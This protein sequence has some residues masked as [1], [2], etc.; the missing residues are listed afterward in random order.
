MKRISVLIAVLLITVCT[1]QAAWWWSV[2]SENWQQHQVSTWS[3]A[4]NS[5]ASF[6]G[7]KDVFWGEDPDSLGPWVDFYYDGSFVYVYAVNPGNST[8]WYAYFSNYSDAY[9]AAEIELGSNPDFNGAFVSS[10][11]S[12]SKSNRGKHLGKQ[13]K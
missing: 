5:I 11:T 12:L 13:V 9:A 2:Q 10:S 1:S 4:T 8:L 6:S 7:N 3:E